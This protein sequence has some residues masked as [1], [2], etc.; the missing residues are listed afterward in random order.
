LPHAKI[1]SK[2]AY[3]NGFEAIVLNMGKEKAIILPG[4]TVTTEKS[5]HSSVYHSFFA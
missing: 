1:F 2:K 3:V 4:R 5:F